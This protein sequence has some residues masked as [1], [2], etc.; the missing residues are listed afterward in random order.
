[1][2]RIPEAVIEELK[3]QVDLVALVQSKGVELKKHGA[4]DLVGHCPFHDDRTPSLVVTPEKNLWHC[5]GACQMGGS[6]VDW[7]MK[8]EGVSFRHAV[9]L[10]RAG[11]PKVILSPKIGPRQATVPKLPSPVALEAD[12]QASLNQVIEFY[13]ETLLKSPE[14]LAYL[15][16]RGIKNDEAIKKFKLGFANR[17]LA[18]RLPDKNRNAGAEIR[19]RLQKLGIMRDTGHEH[20]NGS[21]VIPVIGRDGN[22]TEVYGRKITANLK[23]GASHT[24]LPGPHR[25]IWN[26]ECFDSREVILCEALIDALTFWVNGFTNVTASYGIEGFTEEM[27]AGFISHGVR[28]V[29]IAYDRDEAGERG[30]EKLAKKL[31]AEGIECSRVHF[32]K[33]MDAN[34]YGCRMK[35]ASAALRV[36]L[37]A[38]F[39]M[40]KPGRLTVPL[41][42]QP[43]PEVAPKIEEPEAAKKEKEMPSSSLAA[44]GAPQVEVPPKVV[45]EAKIEAE[46]QSE[47]QSEVQENYSRV[48]IPTEVRGDDILIRFGEREYRVRGLNKNLSYDLMRVNIRASV[49][50]RYHIDTLDLYNAKS[51]AAYVNAAEEETGVKSDVIKRDLGRVLMKL[52]EFQEEQIRKALE[53]EKT[54]AVVLSESEK[55][56]ALDFL[57]SPGL[58][59]KI[60]V[61][62]ERCGVVGEE[63]NILVGY[64]ASVSRKLEDPLAVIIQSSSAAGKSSLM[65]AVLAMIPSEEKVKYSAMTGQSLFYMGEKEPQEQDSRHCR[66]R[67]RESGFLRS[68]TPAI[69]GRN[70]YRLDGKRSCV[71]KTHHTR[72]P[73]RGSGDDL[74]HHDRNRD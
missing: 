46:V 41:P 60:L 15:E 66:G 53:S 40:G 3:R 5:M 68:E 18:L 73:G 43:E 1:M 25:G 61:D 12:E 74:P 69:G 10:L 44:A 51:R 35:P 63:T 58:L 56:T 62:F 39:S 4:N 6:V 31:I 70:Q 29:Y 59:D 55:N 14:C 32:P 2:A 27:L 72:V 37:E 36:C 24:Y 52:E 26:P 23:T 38:A 7:V 20:F 13:H 48:N 64:L 49:D 22:V 9:E 33:G 19:G 47:P 57:S 8:C 65:E 67:R 11:D 45:E 42:M 28:R 50:V 17:T 30:A 21:F 71:W 54:Q 34:S 16:K